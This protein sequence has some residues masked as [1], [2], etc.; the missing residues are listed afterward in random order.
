MKIDYIY[1]KY[2]DYGLPVKQ[3]YLTICDDDIFIFIYL[4]IKVERI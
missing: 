1:T 4:M 2:R 3:I